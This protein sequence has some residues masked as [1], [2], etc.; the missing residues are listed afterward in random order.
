MNG[1]QALL[2]G[3]SL[4]RRHPQPWL[5]LYGANLLSAL[6]LAALPALALGPDLARRPVI[7]D[8]ADGLDAWLV[9]ETSLS[10]LASSALEAPVDAAG[11]GPWAFLAGLVLLAGLP[12]AA[13]LPPAFIEGGLLLTFLQPGA[14]RWRAFLAACWHWWG[15]FFLLAAVQGLATTMLVAPMAALAAAAGG[16]AWLGLAVLALFLA[17]GLALVEYTRLLSVA[18][19]TRN[20]FR[21]F[22]MA[23]R[24]LSRRLPAV[25]GLY[26]LSLASVALLHVTY[27]LGLMPL[28]P[29][30]WWPL[31][32]AVQQSF[33]LLRLG[34]RLM[35]LAGAAALLR[36]AEGEMPRPAS[37]G[38]ESAPLGGWQA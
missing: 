18:Q 29:L 14:F 27:R 1:W 32:L 38:A 13:W 6:L 16:A 24:F 37:P 5:L 3:I 8:V 35:R 7:Q 12:L 22:T 31:V 11:S 17:A 21:A 33:I 28:L 15:I 10:P 4:A 20:P 26:A 36:Q 9:L 19:G 2:R 30:R 23:A 34:T 25:A